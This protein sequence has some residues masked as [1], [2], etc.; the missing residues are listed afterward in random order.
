M[1]SYNISFPTFLQ[2]DDCIAQ[3]QHVGYLTFSIHLDTLAL[4]WHE[5]HL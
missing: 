4:N 1:L 3:K 2:F 5:S